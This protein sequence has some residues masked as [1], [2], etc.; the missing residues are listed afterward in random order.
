MEKGVKASPVAKEKAGAKAAA[1]TAPA[2]KGKR[3]RKPKAPE[4]KN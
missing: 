4:S 1:P 3:G 2:A